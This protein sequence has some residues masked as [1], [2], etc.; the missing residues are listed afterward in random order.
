MRCV[1]LTATAVLLVTQTLAVAGDLSGTVVAKGARD[2]RDAV[3][4]L[5]G[6][7]GTFPAP[8]KHTVMNQKNLQFIPHVLPILAGTTVDYL[9]DDDV[10]HNVFTPAKEY[11]KFNLGSWPKGQ[12][13]SHTFASECDLVCSP[14]MLCN[15]HPEMEAY[16]V[17]LKNPFFAVTGKDG[18]FAIKGI[19]AGEY[20]VC[21]WHEKLKGASAKVKI[22]ASGTASVVMNL[23]R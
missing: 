5:K 21:V 20:E 8:K 4:F 6:V 23:H 12:V 22:A 18:K 1:A 11:D 7:P 3:V 2:N 9:N 14:V 19:P 10:L 15:V 17:V 16:V 13:R